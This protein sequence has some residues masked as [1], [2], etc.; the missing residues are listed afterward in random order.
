MRAFRRI[1]PGAA[2]FAA[3]TLIVAACGS[4]GDD[5]NSPAGGNT[6][7]PPKGEITIGTSFA[8]PESQVVAEM[9]AQV[10]EKAGYTVNRELDIDSRDTGN[11]ALESGDIDL[12]PE[13]LGFELPTLDPDADTSGAPED[14]AP[15]LEAAAEANGLVTFAYS[16]ANSTNALVVTR[17]TADANSLSGISDLAPL[18][19]DMS[20]GAPP[21]CVTASFCAIGLKDTYGVEFAEIKSLDFGGPLTKGALKQGAIDVALLFSLDPEIG[22]EDWVVLEDDQNLQVVGNI[23][24][25]VREEVATDELRAL[26]DPVTESLTDEVMIDLVGRIGLDQE[27]VADVAADHL[28]AA[29]LL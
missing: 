27:D 4:G 13:Y 5:D 20:L 7:A 29:G 26:L 11:A 18:A 28:T 2:L 10:L 25:L 17:E 24:P 6:S 9:Y 12:K 3:L 16:P 23:L 8:G 14:V 19:S 21:D 22:T 15:R 1:V